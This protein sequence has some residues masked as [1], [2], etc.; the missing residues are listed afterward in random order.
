MK[1]RVLHEDLAD[2]SRC[3][4]SRS[5]GRAANPPV[6]AYGLAIFV[7]RSTPAYNVTRPAKTK[8]AGLCFVAGDRKNGRKPPNAAAEANPPSGSG[9][10]FR[11]ELSPNQGLLLSGGPEDCLSAF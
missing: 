11:A 8:A 3:H 1:D 2:D 6:Y 9:D 5:G 7:N 4:G 10:Y